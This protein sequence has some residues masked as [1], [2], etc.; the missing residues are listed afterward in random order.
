MLRLRYRCA[1][2]TLVDDVVQ[3]TFLDLWRGG[4]ERYRERHGRCYVD[5]LRENGTDARLTCYSRATHTFLSIPGLV[6]AAR[7]ARREILTFL[8]SHLDPASR[9]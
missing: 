9:G 2:E 5:R 6:P 1:D 3:E 7:P 4:A 8:R